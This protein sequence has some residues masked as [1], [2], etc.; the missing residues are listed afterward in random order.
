MR[1]GKK[2]LSPAAMTS[3]SDEKWREYPSAPCLAGKKLDGSSRL[4]VET[5]RVV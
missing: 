5:A 2:K 4:D 3:A 1:Y